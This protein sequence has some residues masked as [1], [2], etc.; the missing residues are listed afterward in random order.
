[1]NTWFAEDCVPVRV[2]PCLAPHTSIDQHADIT[3]Q[4]GNFGTFKHY[5][6]P[7]W[8]AAVAV[9][10]IVLETRKQYDRF[11][12]KRVPP[13]CACTDIVNETHETSGHDTTSTRL[14][15]RTEDLLIYSVSEFNVKVLKGGGGGRE[16]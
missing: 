7:T 4:L 15:P 14:M 3:L 11:F 5:V 9:L 12:A 10:F 8:A 6:F 16:R 1:M 13:F 2:T